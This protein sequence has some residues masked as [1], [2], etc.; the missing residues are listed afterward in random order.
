VL[1]PLF[2]RP[3][4]FDE[5]DAVLAE[6]AAG[7]LVFFSPHSVHGSPP[8]R[9]ERLR[10]ALI[11]TYQPADHRMFKVDRVRNVEPSRGGERRLGRAKP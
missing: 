4:Q 2:T 11:L 6:L 7:S 9:S 10:R 8:N 3:D 1:G 5:Q